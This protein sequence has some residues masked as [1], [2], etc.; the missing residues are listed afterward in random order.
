[1]HRATSAKK[2]RSAA[3]STNPIAP[4]DF[5][6]L[7]AVSGDGDADDRVVLGTLSPSPN[8][9]TPKQQSVSPATQRSRLSLVT[10]VSSA[11]GLVLPTVGGAVV[12]K[13]EEEPETPTVIVIST[14]E[15]ESPTKTAF[16]L[17]TTAAQAQTITVT[18][19]GFA[20]TG[21]AE[22]EIMENGR[23]ATSTNQAQSIQLPASVLNQSSITFLAILGSLGQFP[24]RAGKTGHWRRFQFF[25]D[26]AQAGVAVLASGGI[27]FW[28]KRKRNRG[29]KEVR[30]LL[31]LRCFY[32][33]IICMSVAA[34]S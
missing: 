21:T 5:V 9:G 26:N 20:P 10:N 11:T 27:I 22:M 17:Q 6:E 15:I 18:A 31:L 14:K 1:M 34:C 28:R 24:S 19:P 8:F 7:L 12:Q 33:N 29:K 4:R 16:I 25:T 3:A 32:Q 13:E 30:R 2:E 23:G